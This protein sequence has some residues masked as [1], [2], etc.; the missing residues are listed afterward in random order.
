M[1]PYTEHFVK[2]GASP[3]QEAR[4]IPDLD[5]ALEVMK[6]YV[7][8]KKPEDPFDI[9]KMKKEKNSCGGPKY[10]FPED[11]DEK[12]AKKDDDEEVPDH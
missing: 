1:H 8:E 9:D 5:K 4:V 12:E 10:L 11:T 2:N 7:T 3:G 6:D